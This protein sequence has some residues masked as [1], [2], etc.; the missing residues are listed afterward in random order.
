MEHRILTPIG[1]GVEISGVDVKS[2]SKERKRDIYD[3]WI[4]HGVMVIKDQRL[5]PKDFLEFAKVIGDPVVQ[6]VSKFSVPDYP[7]IGTISNTDLPL[8]NGKFHVR[9]ENYHTDHSNFLA[10]P[11]ATM[12]YAI[13]IPEEGGDTQYVDVRTA[14]EE[15]PEYVKEYVKSLKSLHIYESSN[16]PRKMIELSEEERKKMP[17]A[18]QPIVIHHP[19]CKRKALYLNTGRMEGVDGLDP[20]EGRKLIDLLYAHSTQP[21][22][23]YRHKWTP[24]D[25]VVWDNRSVMHQANADYDPAKRRFLYRIMAY[26]EALTPA[27]AET[28]V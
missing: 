26:G 12:L 3:L 17:E 22:F 25:I 24:G 13:N 20:G 18:L 23:E 19:E 1:L 8:R 15:L 6:Q 16:S 11:K 28:A 14:Y 5:E 9:G 10:P 7:Q 2:L 4:R 27:T 21:K